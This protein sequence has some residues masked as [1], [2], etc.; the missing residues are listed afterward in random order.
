M[1]RAWLFAVKKGKQ[2]KIQQ[3]LSSSSSYQ[4]IIIILNV[5]FYFQTGCSFSALWL[6]SWTPGYCVRALAVFF[7][8]SMCPHIRLISFIKQTDA[9]GKKRLPIRVLGKK[10]N[11]QTN[12]KIQALAKMQKGQTE[13]GKATTTKTIVFYHL[14]RFAKFKTRPVYILS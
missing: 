4:I 13:V 14:S 6:A 7:F 10:T 12:K 1:V 11:K 2:M 5:D 8:R 9:F 3:S